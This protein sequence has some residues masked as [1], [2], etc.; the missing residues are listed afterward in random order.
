MTKQLSVL[1]LVIVA[2]MRS[3]HTGLKRKGSN[4][5][6]PGC[7]KT[8]GNVQEFGSADPEPQQVS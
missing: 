8:S 5:F 6:Q 4:K 1:I 2:G 7:E 3:E